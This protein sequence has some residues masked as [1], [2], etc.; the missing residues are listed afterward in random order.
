MNMICSTRTFIKIIKCLEVQNW[1]GN[2]N[3]KIAQ[4]SM[5]IT[6]KTNK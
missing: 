4:S 3:K 6:L 5:Q 1:C 2:N